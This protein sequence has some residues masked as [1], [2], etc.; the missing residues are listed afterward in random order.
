MFEF[1]SSHQNPYQRF[2]TVDNK[3]KDEYFISKNKVSITPIQQEESFRA[4]GKSINFKK[5]K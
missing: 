2:S 1:R 3:K 4:T 5:C